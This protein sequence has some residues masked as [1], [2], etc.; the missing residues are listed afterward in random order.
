M[1]YMKKNMTMLWCKII[2]KISVEMKGLT[3]IYTIFGT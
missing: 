1:P 3:F 2:P